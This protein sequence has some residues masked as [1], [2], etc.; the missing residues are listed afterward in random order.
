MPRLTEWRRDGPS[1]AAKVLIASGGVAVLSTFLPWFAYTDPTG[2]GTA[3]VRFLGIHDVTGRAML[4]AGLVE[5][6]LGILYL[7]ARSARIRRLSRI[8]MV[9]VAFFMITVPLAA[10]AHVG[11]VPGAPPNATD[12]S[13][14]I[15]TV[16][17]LLAAFV[18]LAASWLTVLDPKMAY[19]RGS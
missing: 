15:G 13:G 10:M 14:A 18:C 16:V 17:A 11:A 9:V 6:T 7:R 3:T 2:S 5:V 19:R 1:L 4:L 8:A 12:A